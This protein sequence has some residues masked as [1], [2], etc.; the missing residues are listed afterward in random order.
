MSEAARLREQSLH[1]LS[2]EVFAHNTAAI[3]LYRKSGFVD[4]GRCISPVP[5]G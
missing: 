4:E 5:S 1:K 3:A 2:L